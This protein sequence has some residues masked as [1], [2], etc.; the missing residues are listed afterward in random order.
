MKSPIN[1]AVIIYDGVELIDMNGPID[2]FLH[3]NSIQKGRYHIYT[4]AGNTQ[5]VKSEGGVVTII[6]TYDFHN[7]PE[8]DVLIVPGVLDS[9]LSSTTADAASISFIKEVLLKDRIVLSVCVGLYNIAATGMINGKCVTTHYLAINSFH[10][11]HKEIKIIKNQ[12]FVPDGKLVSTGGITSGIDGAL[13]LVETF[14]GKTIA[15]QIADLLVY[16]RSAPL[17]PYTML[18]PYYPPVTQ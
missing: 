18:P 10:L 13:H 4:V 11:Q 9:E 16:N 6:P 15:D 3:V 17:P 12:R 5:P 1:I 14:D 8:P 2:V 7:C